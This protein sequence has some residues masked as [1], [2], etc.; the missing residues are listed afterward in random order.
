M[1]L[2]TDDPVGARNR[3][4]L[5]G[6]VT[7]LVLGIVVGLSVGWLGSRAVD[8]TGMDDVKAPD[9]QP[10]VSEDDPI[11][12]FTASSTPTDDVEETT[13]PTEPTETTEPTVTETT[14]TEEPREPTITASPVTAKE[15]EEVY[16]TGR[17]PG[18]GPDIS[19]QVERKE[20]GVW[21]D[22][23]VTAT[24]DER[25]AYS[26]YVQTGQT[27]ANS[28]RVTAESGESTP[29]VIVEIT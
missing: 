1:N 9:N 18:L 12:D 14:E 29:T 6:L 2:N 27:G 28:F 23:P 15:M 3:A 17:F 7:L 24:T 4:I 21:A 5:F 11:D 8:S 16:L 26:T 13:E 25:G 10:G 22:F 19:L 20:G